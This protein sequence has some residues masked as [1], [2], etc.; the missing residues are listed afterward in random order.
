M[1]TLSFGVNGSCWKSFYGSYDICLMTSMFFI[2]S[3]L[4]VCGFYYLKQFLTNI[5]KLSICLKYLNNACY[6]SVPKRNI[7]MYDDNRL[8]YWIIFRL[9]CFVVLFCSRIE[10]ICILGKLNSFVFWHVL[11]CVCSAA[12]G[13][14]AVMKLN[15]FLTCSRNLRAQA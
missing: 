10:H 8:A 7:T 12:N 6:F 13:T 1:Y 2:C 9:F 4:G 3:L 14:G 5:P 15:F 11:Q